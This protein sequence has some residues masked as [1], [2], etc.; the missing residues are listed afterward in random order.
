MEDADSGVKCHRLAASSD[1]S[2]W[3]LLRYTLIV[4]LYTQRWE[5]F[6]SQNEATG[7]LKT[8]PCSSCDSSALLPSQNS[9]KVCRRSNSMWHLWGTHFPWPILSLSTV[10]AEK[11][12][13]P[14][15]GPCCSSGVELCG[16]ARVPAALGRKS[17]FRSLKRERGVEIL[18]RILD[19][20]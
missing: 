1:G 9:R 2:R 16:R 13:S 20:I 12:H 15:I 11:G 3:F 8:G 7:I 17:W 10:E 4:Y 19:P 5:S 14:P 6:S 18:F